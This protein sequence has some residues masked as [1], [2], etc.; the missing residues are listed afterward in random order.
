MSISFPC[1][2]HVFNLCFESL[3]SS[4]SVNVQAPDYRTDPLK[5]DNQLPK[6]PIKQ[7]SEVFRST[8]QKTPKRTTA[9]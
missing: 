4:S 9:E 3:K 7:T 2:V 6:D 5:M 8:Y 1:L